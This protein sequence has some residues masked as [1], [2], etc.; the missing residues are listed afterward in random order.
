LQLEPLGAEVRTAT[1]VDEAMP[2]VDSFAPQV[3]VTEAVMPKRDGYDLLREVRRLAP[4]HASTPVIALTAYARAEDA[5]RAVQAGF[6]GHLRKP[7]DAKKLASMI[8]SVVRREDRPAGS[9]R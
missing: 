5:S 9:G 3:I 6:A 7:V 8:S 4:A 2:I 1:S